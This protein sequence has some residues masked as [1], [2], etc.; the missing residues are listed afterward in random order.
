MLREHCPASE[1]TLKGFIFVSLLN[2][3]NLGGV[4]LENGIWISE[5]SYIRN[6]S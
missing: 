1:T 5:I 3:A 4:K 2:F 6:R